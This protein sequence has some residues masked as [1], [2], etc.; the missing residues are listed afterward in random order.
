MADEQKPREMTEEQKRY[1]NVGFINGIRAATGR[2]T[3]LGV[4]MTADVLLMER[5]LAG[6][7]KP[8]EE[9]DTEEKAPEEVPEEALET[10]TEA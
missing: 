10:P 1:Y 8:V 3:D 4:S 7:V 2:Y 5:Q 6:E 9:T